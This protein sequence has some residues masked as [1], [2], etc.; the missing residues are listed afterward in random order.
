M[1]VASVLRFS[2]FLGQYTA[3]LE[4]HQPSV[5]PVNQLFPADGRTPRPT[6]APKSPLELL[7]RQDDPGLCGYLEGDPEHPL[8]CDPGWNCMYDDGY[9]WFGC[10]TG[11]AITDC[12]VYT[13]CVNSISIDECLYSSECYDDALVTGCVENYAPY[14]ATLYSVISDSTYGHYGCANRKTSYEVM[15]TVSGEDDISFELETETDIASFTGFSSSM[16]EATSVGE[17]GGSM[18][19]E[20]ESSIIET[21]QTTEIE[22]STE[23]REAPT[24]VQ[25]G[26]A[27][28]T[29]SSGRAERTAGVDIGIVGA[30]GV[31]GLLL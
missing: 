31:L 16:S 22:T 4:L 11:T 12:D 23:A 20:A 25:S 17:E 10:C 19:T 28:T 30:A 14:C 3:A 21:V 24:L 6:S 2:V 5:T 18:S 26:A 8:Y 13:A 27:S 1:Y 29:A 7:R 9:S 15:V